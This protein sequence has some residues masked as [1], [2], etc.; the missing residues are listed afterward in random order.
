MIF[1]RFFI[2]TIPIFLLWQNYSHADEYE[3]FEKTIRPIFM[4]HC[5]DC[6]GDNPSVDVAGFSVTSRAGIRDGG[7]R[8]PS[9]V[10]GE[11]EKSLLIHAVRYTE[12]DLQMP[13]G[14]KLDEREIKALER[15]VQDGAYDPRE[16]DNPVEKIKQN[17]ENPAK[18]Q[19]ESNH[20]A[21]QPNSNPQPPKHHF[22]EWS[23]NDIDIFIS[24]RY[25]KL[26]LMPTIPADK[27]TLL[28]RVTF[29]LIGLPPT[30]EEIKSFLNDDSPNA[31]E[32]VIDRLLA[33]PHYGERWGR[34]WL[35][36]VRYAD[37]NGLDENIGFPNAYKYR[38]YVINSMNQ[39][40]PYDQ[41]ITEQLAG[42][43]ME[44]Y[45]DEERFERLT[46][47]GF[48]ALGPKV[49]A[50]QDLAKRK[51]DI[52]DEQLDVISKAFLGQTVACARCH[53]HKFDPIPTT[54]Y[55][56]LAGI[57]KSIKTWNP[58]IIDEIQLP[59]ANEKTIATYEEY[60][61]ELKTAEKKLERYNEKIDAALQEEW[62]QSFSKYLVA[63][64][65]LLNDYHPFN[66][67]ENLTTTL[68]VIEESNELK[69]SDESENGHF[70]E[71]NFDA[72][73]AG[74][75][76]V[77]IR[78]ISQTDHPL[79]II[80]NGS[81][82]TDEFNLPKTY[83]RREE[84][85][86][87]WYT[88]GSFELRNG[89]NTI[90]LSSDDDFPNV[91]QYS[92]IPEKQEKQYKQKLIRYA[93]EYDLNTVVIEKWLEFLD[94]QINQDHSVI[95]MWIQITE[96]VNKE[97]L[98]FETIFEQWLNTIQNTDPEL[99]ESQH[100]Q[101][102]T[103]GF[104]PS[105]LNE[106]AQRIQLLYTSAQQSYEEYS[107]LKEHLKEFE[108][109]ENAEDLEKP[110]ESMRHLWEDLHGNNG[111]LLIP[112][113]RE[114]DLYDDESKSQKDILKEKI[115]AIQKNA[116][117]PI[118]TVM[119]VVEAEPQDT[120]VHIRGMHTSLGKDKIP[121]GFLSVTNKT[122]KQPTINPK[123]SGRLALAKWL[124]DPKHPLTSRVMVNRI[125][126]GHFGVGLVDT[127]N[128]FGIRGSL[129]THPE[130]LDYLAM[131][132]M[133]SGWSMKT[134]HK[135]ILMSN[136]YQMSSVYDKQNAS[137]D[138]E[139]RNYWRMN[140]LRLEAEPI[141]DALLAVGGSLDLTM[142]GRVD[143]YR[144]NGYIFGEGGGDEQDKAFDTNRRSIYVPVIRNSMYKFFA[145]FDYGGSHVSIGKRA[146]TVVAPQSLIMMNSE[147]VVKQAELLAERILT[148]SSFDDRERI[149][150][151]FEITYG[152]LPS[153]LEL[154]DATLFLHEM[155]TL[156]KHQRMKDNQAN[157]G[158]D[159][160]YAWKNLCHV[161]LASNE[162]I[163]IN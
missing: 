139:N 81:S 149:E 98:P 117:P 155:R 135:M 41:F 151:L 88:F 33:S 68:N 85:Q 73:N 138:P 125:W 39:D 131:K 103:N 147:I 66:A 141:R 28:R 2:F 22:K 62:I 129:P 1:I 106:L 58:G 35:D 44:S 75:Y 52:V 19:I 84:E 25:S 16:D 78:Y 126:Q 132:F 114:S 79:Q 161:L 32:K 45:T 74:N 17:E 127:P 23:Q 108:E 154:K 115:S 10:P 69:P 101:Y 8:G 136:T 118:P 13:P 21:Y 91:I 96:L 30:Q 133:E 56:A 4:K 24:A 5:A 99:L 6:H 110:F 122:L 26:G 95:N 9:V 90:R 51:M 64:T 46:A 55:Y 128:N 53:D 89:V 57:F 148:S 144:P 60:Q 162:F 97:N 92:I 109:N 159:T 48:L 70:V 12:L 158:P 14:Y 50:E 153:Y 160:L 18:G 43:L 3:F 87:Q 124:T 61:N 15:W 71:W 80:V 76:F 102:L 140:R 65:K 150:Q 67:A 130:L 59:L 107:V 120:P 77:K 49:L 38:D 143:T 82:P 105:S 146:R 40:K 27:R 145:G 111:L 121:R 100:F 94:D 63:S 156:N 7:L 112:L 104:L 123:Q 152:R 36:V 11:P 47:L 163:Y 86:S 134:M 54:D 119:G 72:E 116:P 31:Y 42:D 83:N 93:Y 142:H 37:S 29:N 157:K 34:H 20:W 137:I 113:N